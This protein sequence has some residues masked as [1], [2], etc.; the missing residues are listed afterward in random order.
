MKLTPLK[1]YR[2]KGCEIAWFT[3]A[4]SELLYE[5]RVASAALPAQSRE[6]GQS[7]QPLKL[8][9]KIK[10][11]QGDKPDSELP[12]IIKDSSQIYGKVGML[13]CFNEYLIMLGILFKTKYFSGELL[14]QCCGWPP[15]STLHLLLQFKLHSIFYTFLNYQTPPEQ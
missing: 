9:K 14:W 7:Q 2:I 8:W 11:S 15:H 1:Q 3:S 12:P 5:H 13:G 6:L 10:F 4:L